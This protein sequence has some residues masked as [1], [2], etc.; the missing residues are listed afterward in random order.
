MCEPAIIARRLGAV[1]AGEG[2]PV[3]GT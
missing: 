2:A 3:Q 1:Y